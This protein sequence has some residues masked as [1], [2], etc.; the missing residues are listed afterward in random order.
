MMSEL[1]LILGPAWLATLMQNAEAAALPSTN[2]CSCPLG[3]FV[4]PC[5]SNYIQTSALVLLL[6]IHRERDEKSVSSIYL[7]ATMN[8][9][10][11]NR[12]ENTK[13]AK[14][15]QH[16]GT[17]DPHGWR[18]VQVCLIGSLVLVRHFLTSLRKSTQTEHE[19]SPS[20]YY[21]CYHTLLCHNG[22]GHHHSFLEAAA[23]TTRLDSATGTDE[24]NKPRSSSCRYTIVQQEE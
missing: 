6:S 10:A 13:N 22:N 24:H 9:A 23:T 14:K 12:G 2:I 16:C 4:P 18:T 8:A 17:Y 7:L 11:T 3:F 19:T 20:Y 1:D 5:M 21:D 15:Q